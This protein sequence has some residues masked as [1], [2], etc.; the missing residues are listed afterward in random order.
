MLL[1]QT[2]GGFIVAQAL[3]NTFNFGVQ[4]P[5]L[6][7]WQG[8]DMSANVSLSHAHYRFGQREFIGE[9]PCN[10]NNRGCWLQSQR[11][12]ADDLQE[13]AMLACQALRCLLLIV[14]RTHTCN[15]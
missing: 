15:S 11:A 5:G 13:L 10:Q 6:L 2:L 3:E 7:A 14:W 1:Y 8:H 9:R 12:A 4:G